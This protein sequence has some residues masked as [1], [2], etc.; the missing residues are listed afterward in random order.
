R[1]KTKRPPPPSRRGRALR[2]DR[3]GGYEWLSSPPHYRPK[4][5]QRSLPRSKERLSRNRC[6]RPAQERTAIASQL[7]GAW[8]H[9]SAGVSP[10]R[11]AV[12]AVLAEEPR[13]AS[14]AE[15]G[16][17]VQARPAPEGAEASLAEAAEVAPRRAQAAVRRPE[18]VASQ[19]WE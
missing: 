12:A 5:R 10:L 18:A 19:A 15:A 6:G 13:P 16:E 9:V 7:V 2:G 4:T 11:R 1:W 8:V 14:G 3:R 17:A